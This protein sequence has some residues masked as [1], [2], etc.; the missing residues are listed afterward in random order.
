MVGGWRVLGKCLGLSRVGGKCVFEE[1]LEW[2]VGGLVGSMEKFEGFLE[3]ENYCL[4]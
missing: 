1:R 4:L 2:G 3:N